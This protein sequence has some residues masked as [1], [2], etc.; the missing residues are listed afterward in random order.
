MTGGHNMN[1]IK[2][3]ISKK[4]SIH[5]VGFKMIVVDQITRNET[6]KVLYSELESQYNN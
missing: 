2:Q 6:G 3:Y 5:S 4:T 1:P